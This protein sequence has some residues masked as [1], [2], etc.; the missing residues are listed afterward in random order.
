MVCDEQDYRVGLLEIEQ[1]HVPGPLSF[2]H[3]KTQVQEPMFG[4]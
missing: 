3:V 4:R 2:E 1:A